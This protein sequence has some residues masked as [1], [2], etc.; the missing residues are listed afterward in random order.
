MTTL[1]ESYRTLASALGPESLR[2]K[3]SRFLALSFPVS[4][5]DAADQTLA[6]IRRTYH[7]ATHVCHAL[8]L[9]K[10]CECSRRFSD[11][12]EPSQTAGWP[13][14]QEITGR[15]LYDV[16]VL[17]VRYYGGTKLGTGGLVKA[18][19][20]TARLV[21]PESAIIRVENRDTLHLHFPFE[22]TGEVMACL[23]RVPISVLGQDYHAGGSH[24][25][26][27]VP[28]GLTSVWRQEVMDRTRG[29]VQIEE[30]DT[31]SSAPGTTGINLRNR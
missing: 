8:R 2:I 18:Y 10:G 22:L 29:R 12:G 24:L 6:E 30:G 28:V 19:G 21:L 13:I 15:D 20:E 11:D 26:L 3:A 23:S 16:L 17:V 5:P 1:P 27:S 7:D 14:F 4:D 25:I 9:G 31:G